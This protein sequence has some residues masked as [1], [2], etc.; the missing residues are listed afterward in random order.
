LRPILT[1][2]FDLEVTTVTELKFSEMRILDDALDMHGGYVLNFSDRTMREFFDDEF[3]IDIYQEKYRFNGSSK[4][5]H[6]RAFVKVEDNYTVGRVLRKLWEHRETIPV[7]M[8]AENVDSIKK[9]F[10]DLLIKIEDGAAA[11][12]T[13]VIERFVQDETLEEIIAAIGRDLDAQKPVAAL[14]R[15]HTYC[16]KRFGHLL[17]KHGIAW[18][19]AEPLHGRVGK[20][21]KAI[22]A[23]YPLTDI[24][25]QIIKGGIAVFDKFNY[26]R[27]NRSLAHDNDLISNAEA[28]F[29][30]DSI[31]SIL[32]FIKR[33]E[34]PAPRPVQKSSDLDDTIPF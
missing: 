19:R 29:I 32:R 6:L 31:G 30:F 9:R 18:D 33:I 12:R 25:R 17:D 28:H 26:V 8:Q 20:Y 14:D 7:L 16:M 10:F 34:A 11:P 4:A 2:I 1:G 21:V 15:L 24:S 23:K 3:G 22:E 13:D 27:N 5:K